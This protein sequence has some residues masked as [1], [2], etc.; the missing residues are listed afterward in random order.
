MLCLD[1][2]SPKIS[3]ADRAPITG[4]STV[5]KLNWSYGSRE[6]QRQLR[7]KLAELNYPEWMRRRKK[8]LESS[9]D[10]VPLRVQPSGAGDQRPDLLPEIQ[11]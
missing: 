3:K 11:G 10:P 2:A 9:A 5:N 6:L 7:W 4:S 8:P 1:A